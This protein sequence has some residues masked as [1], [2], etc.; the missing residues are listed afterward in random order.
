MALSLEP[1]SG[2]VFRITCDSAAD[3]PQKTLKH[4]FSL[5]EEKNY[6]KACE[7]RF[8]LAK[9]ISDLFPDEPIELDLSDQTTY[10]AAE[11]LYTS[12]LDLMLVGDCEMGAALLELLLDCDSE[13]HFEA[14][15][16]L[17][18]CYLLLEDA[19]C[20]EEIMGDIDDRT[21]DKALLQLL[22]EYW[23][24][25]TVRP[26]SLQALC[27]HRAL[28]DEIM[29]AEHPTS[30][31]FTRDIRSEHPS[32]AG[33]ARAMYLRYE[34]AFTHFEGFLPYLCESLAKECNF[35]N[36]DNPKKHHL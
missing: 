7:E 28:R 36:L 29:R 8:L 23:K 16:S 24:N 15:P 13:D 11:I 17:A 18:L 4:S 3:S 6:E 19:D 30:D 5:E 12:A 34:P 35:N 20:L 14:T 26:S 10:A 25:G 31:E 33:Q 21:A 32:Q 27:R 2:G 22:V 9:R 1:Y